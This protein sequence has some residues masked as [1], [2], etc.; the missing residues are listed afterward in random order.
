M[1]AHNGMF[2]YGLFNL[3]HYRIYNS[4]KFYYNTCMFY[5]TIIPWLIKTHF[6]TDALCYVLFEI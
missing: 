1:L 6:V 4:L 2:I 3:P 5:S